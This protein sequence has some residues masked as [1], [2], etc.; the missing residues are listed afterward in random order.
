[1]GNELTFFIAIFNG[2]LS[3]FTPCILPLL[4]LYFSYLAGTSITDIENNKNIKKTMLINSIA[5]VIG[6]SILNIMLGFGAKAIS[7]TLV[8]YQEF[9][10]KLGGVLIIIFG[11]YYIGILKIRFF[12]KE[13]KYHYRNYSPSFIKSMLLGITFSFGWTPCNSPIV[14]S[15]LFL[16]SF[17]KNY[18]KAGGMMLIYSIGFAIPFLISAILL[19]KFVN[20]YK[21]IYQYFDKIKI[22]AGLLMIIMGIMLYTNTLSLLVIG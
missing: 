5:F 21:K 15:I 11:L 17:E 13:R 8:Q 7:T 22:I 9:I 14:G 16:A 12:D 4:P 1:M 20:N 18:I 2:F 3:F 10:R 19:S 6:L